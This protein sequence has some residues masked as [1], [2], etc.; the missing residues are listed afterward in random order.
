MEKS[1]WIDNNRQWQARIWI[2]SE[3]SK[4]PTII[5]GKTIAEVK[6]AVTKHIMDANPQKT[7]MITNK[8]YT[9][10]DGSTFFPERPDDKARRIKWGEEQE[11]AA[12]G[13]HHSI[14]N[15]YDSLPSI[16]DVIKSF[17]KTPELIEKGPG[18]KD[19]TIVDGIFQISRIQTIKK[20]WHEKEVN[21]ALRRGWHL[22]KIGEE[23]TY[24]LGHEDP[25]AL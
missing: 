12:E 24:H 3:E 7:L 13:W 18:Y 11:P 8:T 1:I 21:E 15:P 10:A 19:P 22:L 25:D 9:Y 6:T 2:D 17:L 14:Y 16:Q 23:N 4:T 5:Y 20:E